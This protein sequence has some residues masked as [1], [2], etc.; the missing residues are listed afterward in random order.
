MLEGLTPPERV[1]ACRVSSEADKLNDKDREIFFS[2]VND[3]N[4]WPAKTLSDQLGKRGISISDLSIT[5]HRR[6]VCSCSKI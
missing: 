2:A 1:R 6:Q 4:L 3:N 5:R